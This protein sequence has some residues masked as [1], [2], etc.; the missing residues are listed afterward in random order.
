MPS[1]KLASIFRILARVV[2]CIVVAVTTAAVGS[3]QVRGAAACE[4]RDASNYC[5]HV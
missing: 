4:M 2:R 3:L 1:D 5:T